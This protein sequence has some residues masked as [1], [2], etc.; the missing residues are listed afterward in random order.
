MANSDYSAMVASQREF[1]L[2]GATRQAGWHK[3]QLEAVK[4]RFTD[5]HDEL[6][7]ALWQDVRRNVNDTD[8]MDVADCAKEAEY[9][10]EHLGTWMKPVCEPPP[11]VFEPGHIFVHRDPLGVMLMIGAGNK[12]FIPTFGPLAAGNTAVRKP[13]EISVACA[14]AAAR[15]RGRLI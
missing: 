4:A 3:A 15:D 2:S 9:A 11:A 13:S 1:F 14:A 8:L 7:D 12:R 6:C 10:L 5:N